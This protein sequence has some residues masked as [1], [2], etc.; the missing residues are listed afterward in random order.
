MSTVKVNGLRVRSGPSTNSEAV[1]HYDAGQVIKSG[2]LVI[3]NEGRWWL[4]YTASSGAKRFIC[5]IDSDGSVFI[6]V[7]GHI[8][9][10]PGGGPAP[11]PTP[12]TGS[13]KV[14]AYCGCNCCNGKYGNLTAS[15]VRLNQSLAYRV[16]AAP[17]NIPFHTKIHVSGPWNGIVEVVDRGGAIKGNRLDIFTGMNHQ[18]S[19]NFGVKYCNVSW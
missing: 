11:Q 4:R 12:Q 18:E 3:Q 17:P 16:C 6:D 14:T 1:A 15:G 5:A 19:N 2:D 8:P 9:R 7:P 10:Q 13:W